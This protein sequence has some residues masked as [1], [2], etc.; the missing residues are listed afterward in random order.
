VQNVEAGGL[1]LQQALNKRRKHGCT[2]RKLDA[3]TV[4]RKS[5]LA[6]TTH[7]EKNNEARA[8]RKKR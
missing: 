7:R 4:E 3:R 2:A 5:A 1:E 8:S 6:T